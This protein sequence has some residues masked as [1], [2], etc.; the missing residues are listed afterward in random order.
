MHYQSRV[1]TCQLRS[2]LVD[3]LLYIMPFIFSVKGMEKS[4]IAHI[5][6][7][8]EDT[9]FIFY[10]PNEKGCRNLLFLSFLLFMSVDYCNMCDIIVIF[11]VL[12]IYY[13]LPY[14]SSII[15]YNEEKYFLSAALSHSSCKLFC[16]FSLNS[17]IIIFNL[18]FFG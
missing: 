6:C 12:N 17:W 13:S 18:E 10:S 7:R 4:S 11:V 9:L 14:F 8:L 5:I 2:T 3:L 15:L 16:I 1:L